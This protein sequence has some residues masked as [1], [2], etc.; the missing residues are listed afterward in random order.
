[1]LFTTYINFNTSV[2]FPYMHAHTEAYTDIRMQQGRVV[3]LQDI[4][5]VATC[6]AHSVPREREREREREIQVVGSRA[7]HPDCLHNKLRIHRGT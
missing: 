5:H 6:I 7:V 4:V 3:C 1:M 2:T